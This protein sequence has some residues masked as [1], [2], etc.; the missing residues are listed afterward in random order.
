[1]SHNQMF[2]LQIPRFREEMLTSFPTLGHCGKHQPGPI[3]KHSLQDNYGSCVAHD[4]QCVAH[5][6]VFM[7]MSMVYEYAHVKLS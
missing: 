7:N 4:V 2:E 5:G 3:H 1:M 6:M